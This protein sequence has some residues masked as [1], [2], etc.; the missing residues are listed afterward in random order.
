MDCICPSP[1]ALTEIP[2]QDCGVNLK[3]IQRVAIQRTGSQ[4]G[5]N[6]QPAA[7]SI[8]E[9]ADWQALIAAND[10]TKIVIT[11]R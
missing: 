6:T 11:Y 2:A 1:T 5:T 4:F 7:N 8:L 10:D 3:Q 9:L